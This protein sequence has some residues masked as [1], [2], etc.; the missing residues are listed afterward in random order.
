MCR[1]QYSGISFHFFNNFLIDW[2]VL[3]E[4][5]VGI[6]KI[7]GLVFAD[8]GGIIAELLE[9]HKVGLN[10]ISMSGL[11]DPDCASYRCLA[12]KTKQY[13]LIMHVDRTSIS[14]K[15]SLMG[16]ASFRTVI[17]HIRKSSD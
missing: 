5:Y 4:I 3:C 17:G 16:V 1:M 10:A 13:I 9:V 14:W 7:S 6:T 15:I 2:P 8:D 11:L 12:Y